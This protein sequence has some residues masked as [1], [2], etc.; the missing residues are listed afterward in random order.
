ML[1]AG[2]LG[3]ASCARDRGPATAAYLRAEHGIV[4]GYAAAGQSDFHAAAPSRPVPPSGGSASDAEARRLYSDQ[5]TFYYSVLIERLGRESKA[6]SEL[7]D[8]MGAIDPAG[9]DPDAVRLIGDEQGVFAAG[10]AMI[11]EVSLVYNRKRAAL[12]QFEPPNAL[13]DRCIA[14]VEAMRRGTAGTEAYWTGAA[15]DEFKALADT[16]GL[17]PADRALIGE[18]T[19]QF[20]ESQAAA[21]RAAALFQSERS[22]I[23]ESLSAKY[24]GNIPAR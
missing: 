18:Q 9:A 14:G 15:W 16:A 8:R 24:F 10:E 20:R 17:D 12:V 2:A 5:L 11:R 7:R 1:A 3:A 19:A 4:E 21:R 22:R 6:L 23:M 13:D